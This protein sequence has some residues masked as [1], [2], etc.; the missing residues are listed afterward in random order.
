MY[1]L[2]S[3]TLLLSENSKI[4]ETQIFCQSC[5]MPVNDTKLHGTTKDGS[6]TDKFCTYCYQK[7]EFTQD[8][9]LEEMIKICVPHMV[10]SGMPENEARK[11]LESSL[12]NLSRW[13]DK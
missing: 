12:P 10:D 8:V 5:G 3:I 7:G 6:L 11:L 4:M 13:K 2:I 9:S 1:C